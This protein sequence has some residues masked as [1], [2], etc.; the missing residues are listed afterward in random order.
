[1]LNTKQWDSF[2]DRLVCFPRK[3]VVRRIEIEKWRSLDELSG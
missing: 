1:M 3:P 2:Q